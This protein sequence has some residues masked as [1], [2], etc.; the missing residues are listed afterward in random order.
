MTHFSSKFAPQEVSDLVRARDCLVRKVSAPLQ[1]KV[2]LAGD[3]RTTYHEVGSGEPLVLL[4]GAAA[5]GLYWFPVIGPLAQRFRVV[6]PDMVGYGE[7]D[8]PH[9]PYDRPFYVNWFARFL[10]A[11]AIPRAH[12]V[13]LSQGG[14]IAVQF[15]H[16]WPD[17]VDRLVLVSPAGL[18]R[19]I[20]TGYLLSYLLLNAFPNP[21]IHSWMRRYVVAQKGHYDE[22]LAA[23]QLQVQAM[24]GGGHA[25]WDGRGS[26]VAQFGVAALSRLRNDTLVLWGEKDRLFR[27]RASDSSGAIPG[28]RRLVIRDA[29]HAVFFDQTEVFLDAL[30]GFLVRPGSDR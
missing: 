18:G 23:Y 12:L 1:R 8:K 2:V 6:V 17:R 30:M 16:D 28:S 15:A 14:A 29:G 24:K 11:V 26:A 27:R 22:D 13:G 21:R 25:C 9:A 3:V 4:H 7:T 5:G 10:D 20:S 19:R